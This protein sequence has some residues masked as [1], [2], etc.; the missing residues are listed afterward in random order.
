MDVI[1][2]S[3]VI[4]GGAGAIKDLSNYAESLKRILLSTQELAE[5]GAGAIEMAEFAVRQLEDDELFNAGKGS[6]LNAL[7]KIECE[8]SIMDGSTLQAGGVVNVSGIK[9]PVSLA[10][11]VMNESP[12]VILVGDGAMLFASEQG[13]SPVPGSYFVTEARV[14]QL[15]EAQSKGKIVLDHSD[16]DEF[17]LGTVGAVVLDS[18]G[19]LAAATSTGGIVN[20][21]YGR[22]GDSAVMGAGVYA[23]NGLVAVSA[24]GYGEHFLRTSIAKH[25]AEFARH[26]SVGASEAAQ[27]GIDFLVQKVNGLGGVI[28]VDSQGR[29]GVAH[30]TPIILAGAVSSKERKPTLFFPV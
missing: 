6:V 1:N 5:T 8:A 30:S 12:H 18:K 4:H 17:K 21:Q 20:K 23:E 19:N 29:V 16:V 27:A 15:K 7:G 10:K 26:R 9:N 13:V 25:I 2:Y 28:V 14:E 3:I 22:M 11:L 24:T